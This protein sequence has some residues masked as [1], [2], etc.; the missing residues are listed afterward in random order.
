MSIYL[1]NNASTSIDPEFISGLTDFLSEEPM[2][3]SS[4]HTNGQKA[5]KIIQNTKLAIANFLHIQPQ[6]ITFTSGGT[7]SMNSLIF[8]IVKGGDFDLILSTTL[9]HACVY[10]SCLR[11]AKEGF[12]VE[13]IP[14]QDYETLQVDLIK[15]FLKGKKICLITSS[16]NSETGAKLPVQEIAEFS[17]AHNISLILDGVAHLGKEKVTIYPG[18]TAMGFSGH[19][20]HAPK[21]CGFFY[22][23]QGTPLEKISFGGHQEGNRRAGTENLFGIYGLKLAIQ[24][25]HREETLIYT[26][27]ALLKSHFI[28][29]LRSKN[30]DISENITGSTISNT[31]NLRFNELDGETLLICLDQEGIR[32]SMGSA[33]SSGALE[34]SR[35]LLQMGFTKKEAKESLRFS[36]SRLNTLQEVINAC[37]L[38]EK[39]CHKLK[40]L[41]VKI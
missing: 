14:M 34:P 20:I 10:E 32:C 24:K 41:F 13:F 1:D 33:C 11:L 38:I 39:C 31:I 40:N 36:F 9:E 17:K 26:H 12:P 29:E 3:A 8:G 35:V 4:V 18:I 16:V 6:E 21:G 37:T 27:L 2:N 25:L 28:K 30:I 22:L 23:K 15:P 7:E 5:K 19:K